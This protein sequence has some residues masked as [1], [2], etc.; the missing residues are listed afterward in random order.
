MGRGCL[1]GRLG[2]AEAVEAAS[3]IKQG[4]GASPPA[5]WSPLGYPLKEGRQGWLI[6]HP[7]AI[8]EV[9]SQALQLGRGCNFLSWESRVGGKRKRI[10][11][12]GTET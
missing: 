1:A 7:R 12:P 8:A 6:L 10:R 11:R 3:S 5:A 4:L 2:R 9:P